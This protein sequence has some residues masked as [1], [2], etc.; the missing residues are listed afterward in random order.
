MPHREVS[1]CAT[2]SIGHLVSRARGLGKNVRVVHRAQAPLPGFEDFVQGAVGLGGLWETLGGLS[3]GSGLA[4]LLGGS[5]EDRIEP[6]YVTVI[7]L[8]RENQL[9]AALS[10]LQVLTQF[11]SRVDFPRLLHVDSGKASPCR[12][13]WHPGWAASLASRASRTSRSDC[14]PPAPIR[15]HKSPGTARVSTVI[16]VATSN[17]VEADRLRSLMGAGAPILVNPPGASNRPGAE[18]WAVMRDLKGGSAKCAWK[19]GERPRP[20]RLAAAQPWLGTAGLLGD[21]AR[22]V[23]LVNIATSARAA[24]AATASA[25][26]LNVFSAGARTGRTCSG[27]DRSCRR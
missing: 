22:R 8:P 21:T 16:A 18:I 20:T 3:R 15:S 19:A 1:D 24:S 17:P 14:Q 27:S 6:G 4:E 9:G 26:T 2:G 10:T 13:A 11:K 23:R 12:P 25:T 5:I 7:G